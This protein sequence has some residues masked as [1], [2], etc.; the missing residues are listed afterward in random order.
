MNWRAGQIAIT[1]GLVI[2]I[3]ALWT[4]S[5]RINEPRYK[6]K[7]LSEWLDERV[8][9]PAGPIIL[10]DDAAHA[11]QQIGQDAIPLLL[12]WVQRSDPPGFWKLRYV[13][14]I[15]VPL[16]DECR[17]RAFY[18][19]RA[20][21]DDAAPAIPALVDLTLHSR[22][23]DVRSAAINSLV[24]EHAVTT[25]RL[26][27]ALRDTDAEVRLRA[28]FALAC[29]RPP[30]AI[31]L[32]IS[33]LGDTDPKVRREAAKG[34]GCYSRPLLPKTALDAL[35]SRLSDPDSSVR[36]AAQ[37][38]LDWQAEYRQHRIADDEP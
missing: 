24:H 7:L 14:R 11:V 3:A 25:R 26:G 6:G 20:L 32:L 33:A 29:L 15:P 1:M 18:G 27:N 37:L 21:G 36:T 28:A 38:S 17:T 8:T 31:E 5:Q 2:V 16:N 12:H 4:R 34:L 30:A 10:S 9:T 35:Q 22:D 19:F 13:A 23:R